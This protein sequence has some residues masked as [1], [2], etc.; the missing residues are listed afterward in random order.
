LSTNPESPPGGVLLPADTAHLQTLFHPF[1]VAVA[2]ASD[3]ETQYGN[4]VLRHLVQEGS[5][6]L[7]VTTP[8]QYKSY[9]GRFPL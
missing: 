8:Y 4:L 6:V 3:A 1:S 2:G 5:L 9:L 7:A